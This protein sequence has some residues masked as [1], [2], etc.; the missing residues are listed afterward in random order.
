MDLLTLS[1]LGLTAELST[2]LLTYLP[3]NLGP[4]LKGREWTSNYRISEPSE[5]RYYSQVKSAGLE[6]PFK[7]VWT[8]FMLDAVPGLLGE[9][10]S[11]LLPSHR[12]HFA[13]CILSLTLQ[14][15]WFGRKSSLNNTK[16]PKQKLK[17]FQQRRQPSCSRSGE[18]LGVRY[19]LEVLR[20]F[21]ARNLGPPWAQQ[22]PDMVIS[23]FPGHRMLVSLVWASQC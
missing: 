12:I 5:V 3:F 4:I 9:A 13:A 17:C 1:K 23:C 19:F 22:S 2:L 15:C 18:G 21:G 8:Q 11:G 20:K 14:R 10:R 7:H 6:S 16:A